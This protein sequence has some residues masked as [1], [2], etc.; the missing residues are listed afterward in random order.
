MAMA[1]NPDTLFGRLLDHSAAQPDRDAVVTPTAS[2]SYRQLTEHVRR[3]ITD[4]EA[5]GVTADSVVA[6]DCADDTQH[7]VICLAAAATGATSVTLP[8]HDEDIARNALL[9]NAGVTHVVNQA[10]QVSPTGATAQPHEKARDTAQL[11]F[12]TSGT[13]GAAKLVIHSDAG[14]VAQAH[15]HVETAEQRFVC[16]AS[17]EHNFAK[18][19]RLYCVAT[20][21]TNVF[22]DPD[23]QSL[24]EQCLALQAN[25]MH[26]SAFQAQELLAMP[27]VG[28]LAGI[29]LKLGGSHVPAALRAQ[30]RNTISPVLQCG[31]GTTETGAIAFTGVD[32]DDA[33]ESVGQP[34]PGIEVRVVQHQREPV[35]DGEQG[36]LAIRC[37]GM[38]HGYLRNAAQTTERLA[39]GWFYT[40]DIG[41]LD[42]RQRIHLSGRSDDMFVFNSMNIYPQEIE[43]VIRQ[44]PGIEDAAVIPQPSRV[45]GDVPVALIVGTRAAK[46]RQDALRKFVR[47]QVGL[48]CPRRFIIVDE[49]PRNTSGKIARLTASGLTAQ[50]DE[51]RATVLEVLQP[52]GL[53]N[54]KAEQVAAFAR[55]D[56]D[57]SL[58]DI[59]MDSLTRMDLLI[60]LEVRHD[61]IIPPAVFIRDLITLG[62]VVAQAIALQGNATEPEPLE[63]AVGVSEYDSNDK[64]YV[65]RLF[66]RTFS[67]CHTVAQLNQALMTFEF[68]LTPVEFTLLVDRHNNGR[69]LPP[70]TAHKF[71]T[72][73]TTWLAGVQ[74][75][76][77]ASENALPE[78]FTAR[79]VAS[80]L[81]HYTGGGDKRRKTLLIC[82]AP[83][84]GRRLMMPNAVFLQHTDASRYDVLIVAEPRN[85]AYRAGA[86]ILGD[87]IH[88]MIE[89]IAGLDLLDDYQHLR[90]LGCSA[91]CY[92]AVIAA[93]RVG[94]ELAVCSAGRFHSWRFPGQIAERVWNTWRAVRKGSC[95][96]TMMT[97]AAHK[98]R[99]RNYARI[100]ARLSRGSMVGVSGDG[101]GHR[102]LMDLAERGELAPYLA[103]TLFAELN[104]ATV[105]TTDAI[106]PLEITSRQPGPEPGT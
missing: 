42:D 8:G 9:Q 56:A 30:L 13:T 44:F 83:R 99:D 35:P 59:D 69:L 51:I 14:L 98:T 16:L 88:S 46:L 23:P 57:I 58:Y 63:A 5:A 73:L 62:D 82:F 54:I 71:H 49:I 47:R 76:M 53:R 61:A 7:L 103:R 52:E 15:R 21:A 102:V 18:R 38:F 29:R 67:Y 34:L 101:L 40:G 105:T 96:H 55:G 64:P 81:M 65:I 17:M 19:H 20:G 97:F 32:D 80:S 100:M 28:R 77:A 94:A 48:R 66:Q 6:I 37:A 36:E 87:D 68:R 12:A 91:G 11:L 1:A 22:I 26:L 50:S 60:A 106:V 24:V 39:D 4:L 33:G 79:K 89:S 10:A 90:T 3:K 74:H 78:P 43:T 93:F 85:E 25:V 104:D 31:Y 92:P 95:Q 72:A 45:H 84:G 70:D 86:P 75:M 41:H 2:L 27:G